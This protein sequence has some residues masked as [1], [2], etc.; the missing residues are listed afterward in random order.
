MSL[1]AG[2]VSYHEVINS[3]APVS[4]TTLITHAPRTEACEIVAHGLHNAHLVAIHSET[5]DFGVG[6]AVHL[7]F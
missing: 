4:S 3:R 2:T 6:E 7:R 5:D 1:Q